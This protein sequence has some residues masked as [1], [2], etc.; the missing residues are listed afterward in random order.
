M[1]AA[2]SDLQQRIMTQDARQSMTDSPMLQ[3]VNHVPIARGEG[4]ASPWCPAEPTPF[5]FSEF[6][7]ELPAREFVDPVARRLERRAHLKMADVLLNSEET[8]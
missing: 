5:S 3:L 2:W 6:K 1:Q 7:T 4:T 8:G